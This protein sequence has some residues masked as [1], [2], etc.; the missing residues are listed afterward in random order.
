[1]STIL[2]K[3]GGSLLYNEELEI[4]FEVIDK[5]KEWFE[6]QNEYTSCVLVVGGGKLS[7]FITNQ[8]KSKMEADYLRHRIGLKVTQV[9]AA[10][11]HGLL[12]EKDS[13][14][15]E[16]ISDI[17]NFLKNDRVKFS[18]IGG[19]RIGDSTDMTAAEIAVELGLN[20]VN[21]VSNIEYIYSDDPNLNDDAEPYERLS[22][23]QYI[24]LFEEN[25]S[26]GHQPGMSIPV[27]FKSVSLSQENKLRFRI[28]GGDN[29]HKQGFEEMLKGGTIVE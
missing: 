14:Y 20:F 19:T 17:L 13:K 25:F 26:K 21:K 24:Q 6:Q 7:R 5:F 10:L 27:D 8:A 28:C 11:V 12:G 23:D 18:I 9:N 16:E 15:F 22:W 1:M 3:I 29:I 4:N 2:V